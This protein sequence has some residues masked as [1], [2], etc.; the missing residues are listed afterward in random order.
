MKFLALAAIATAMSLDRGL[1]Q[2][3]EDM[4][5]TWSAVEQ[6]RADVK[7]KAHVF[8]AAHQAARKEEGELAREIRETDVAEKEMKDARRARIQA[9]AAWS[10]AKK[11][12]QDAATAMMEAEED[13]TYSR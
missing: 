9:Q 1:T 7:A 11:A 5:E 6:A 3:T 12:T 4:K 8:A 13:A 10:R 2:D